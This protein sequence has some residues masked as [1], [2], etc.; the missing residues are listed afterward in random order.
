[1]VMALDRSQGPADAATSTCTGP[2]HTYADDNPAGTASD[3][4]NVVVAVT[5][6]RSGTGSNAQA[7]TVNNV[8]P[9]ITGITTNSPVPGRPAGPDSGDGDRS[10]AGPLIR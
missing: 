10:G 2:A 9:T 4:V 8:P 3:S 6:S 7:H 5:E 1:M